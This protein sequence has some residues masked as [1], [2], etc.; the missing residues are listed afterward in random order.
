MH[1]GVRYENQKE[2][3]IKLGISSRAFRFKVKSN[4]ITKHI[5]GQNRHYEEATEHDY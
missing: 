3:C 2:S 1:K 4:E 5:N